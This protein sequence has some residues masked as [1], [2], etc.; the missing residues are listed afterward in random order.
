MN[1]FQER[2]KRA[3]VAAWT[4]SMAFQQTANVAMAEGVAGYETE[5]N[6]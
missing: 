4:N 6:A 3:G 1:G 2:E 5:L